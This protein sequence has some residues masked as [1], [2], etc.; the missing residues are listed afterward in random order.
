MPP[1]LANFLIFLVETGF[2]HV[3]Q[4]GLELLT[5]SD[6]PTSA[7][8]S[9]GITGMSL[10]GVFVLNLKFTTFNDIWGISF[11]G[12]WMY[13]SGEGGDSELS[14]LPQHVLD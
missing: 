1:C 11:L 13:L 3:G 12:I 10:A 5:S 8:Q 9:A 2:R 4:T 6:P 7:S 14:F